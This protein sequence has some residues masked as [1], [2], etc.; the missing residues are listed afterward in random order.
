MGNC[1][2]MARGIL[3]ILMVTL[4]A[5]NGFMVPLRVQAAS[6]EEF[7]AG[8]GGY[9]IEGDWETLGTASAN[10]TFEGKNCSGF[11]I[12][13]ANQ[14]LV[15]VTEQ[16]V[17]ETEG[18]KST[19]YEGNL[20]EGEGNVRFAHYK[21]VLVGEIE[22]GSVV[23]SFG[24]AETL[25][26][27]RNILDQYN[28]H[29]QEEILPEPHE[30]DS[31][32]PDDKL[33]I[34]SLLE[35]DP[36]TLNLKS[37]GGWITVYIELSKRPWFPDIDVT[38]IDI[39][40]VKLNNQVPAE[41]NPKY[42]FVKDPKSYIT[43]HDG[44]GV[45]ERMVKFDRARV[46]D[47]LQP[48]DFVKIE[49]TGLLTDGRPFFGLNWIKVIGE[50]SPQ[51]FST[52]SPDTTLN[53]SYSP[54]ECPECSKGQMGALSK[55]ESPPM[56]DSNTLSRRFVFNLHGG[57]VAAGVG[58]R[59]K[60]EGAITI[61]GIPTNSTVEKAFLY[62]DVL[63]D[64]EKPEF[65]QGR[66]D[67]TWI[68]GTLIGSGEDPCWDP[69]M[70]FAYRADVTNLV[71]GNGSYYLTNFASGNTTGC[72]PWNCAQ[73]APLIEGAS[74]VVIYRNDG[75]PMTTI[76]IYD[77]AQ[78]LAATSYTI[79]IT[80]F[81]A[82]S[83]VASASITYLGAD[84][85]DGVRDAAECTY[86]NGVQ[87]ADRDWEG[88]DPREGDPYSSGN[89]WDTNTYNVTSLVNPGD[90]SATARV[91]S[92][93]GNQYIADCLVWV[94]AVFSVSATD[95]PEREVSVLA[96]ADEEY[97][98]HFD[99]G[100]NP[101]DQD[102]WKSEVVKAVELG[103]NAF[104]KEFKINFVV[105]EIGT[106][107][108]DDRVQTLLELF[109]EVRAEVNKGSND[110]MVAFSDQVE[111]WPHP[112]YAEALGDATIVVPVPFWQT[113]NLLQHEL[114]HLFG[115]PDHGNV[116][117]IRCIMSYYWSWRINDWC[118]DCRSTIIINKMRQF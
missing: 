102:Q 12:L 109:D 62:W 32:V 69:T 8:Y 53:E 114:S 77:G 48:S 58:L 78:T 83:P 66:F 99:Q 46:Q 26:S 2:R 82:P 11:I 59:N 54:A 90:T 45:L 29:L 28:D 88:S 15:M 39:N 55:Q 116:A 7:I 24:V 33:V 80:G 16:Y 41:N 70:N 81:T 5:F 84:G 37:K 30:F 106:W 51:V 25:D 97:V 4:I 13:G 72:D 86:F 74:L 22:I 112:G 96:V 49:V 36:N 21:D 50:K 9:G 57:Y 44:D 92:Y 105:K 79:T 3:A 67:G 87:I 34:P 27:A 76:V 18:G 63:D 98:A 47:T 93:Y 19:V 111:P 43:D 94:A 107:D 71:T 52:N 104:E 31:T 17:I 35:I 115:A 68:E 118:A 100:W 56:I 23:Y 113:D 64:V 101:W 38:K 91:R 40:T 10:L 42:G 117:G 20:T 85:Q 60:G 73:V 14:Y 103:D 75:S 110:V 108:S 65:K 1:N 61:S 95:S 89:L 6:I